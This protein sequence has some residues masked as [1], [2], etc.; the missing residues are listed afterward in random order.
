M[1]QRTVIKTARRVVVKI[2]SRLLAK[3]N[4]TQQNLVDEMAS[5]TDGRRSFVVVSRGAIALG[6]QRLGYRSRPM[7][8]AKLQAAAA[9]GQSVLMRRYDEFFGRHGITAAQVLITHADLA[10]RERLNNA[11]QALAALIESRAVPVINENDTVSTEQVQFGDN[12]QLAAMVTP[13]V[14]AEVL[15]LLTDVDGVLNEEGKRI[16]V[17]S[18]RTRVKELPNGDA[19]V[20]LGGISSKLDAAWKACRAG[21]TAVIA[22]ASRPRVLQSILMGADVGTVFPAAGVTLRARKHWIAFTLRPKGTVV[23]DEGAVKAIRGGKSSLLPVGVVGV[24]GQFNAGDSVRLV[25]PDGTEVGR[26]LTRLGT[27]DV[28]RAAGLRREGLTDLFGAAADDWVVVHKDDLVLELSR[29]GA[30]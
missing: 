22:P 8:I 5:L 25:A 13:L 18:E 6:C 16:S 11:R 28:A 26:G 21:A 19:Q 23:L 17:M 15:V 2:G 7:E 9:A 14:G 12:D 27:V 1:A 20:G 30:G 24:R 3:G 10:D 29:P 4:E